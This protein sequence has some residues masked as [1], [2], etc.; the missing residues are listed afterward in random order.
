MMQHTINKNNTQ[1]KTVGI[2]I[3]NVFILINVYDKKIDI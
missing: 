2:L 1:N 3:N